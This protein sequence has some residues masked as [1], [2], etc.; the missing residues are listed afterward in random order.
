MNHLVNKVKLKYCHIKANFLWLLYLWF[1]KLKGSY[2][3]MTD[4]CADVIVDN[5][6]LKY[7]FSVELNFGGTCPPLKVCSLTFTIVSPF[8]LFTN[9][10]PDCKPIAIEARRRWYE[11]YK[12]I[13][14]ETETF[15]WKDT[16]LICV[17]HIKLVLSEF[18]LNLFPLA[19]TPLA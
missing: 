17:K 13:Q 16:N 10:I 11:D 7:H 8:S 12:F 18:T 4:L 1:L 6:V 2:L 5:D 9:M 19:I 3:V 14:R 15:V